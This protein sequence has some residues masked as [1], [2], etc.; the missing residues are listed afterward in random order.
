MVE[1][2]F[3]SKYFLGASTRKLGTLNGIK[4]GKISRVLKRLIFKFLSS[5]RGDAG[6]G[7]ILFK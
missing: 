2:T 5:I 3:Q 4:S 1:G 6:E 7:E